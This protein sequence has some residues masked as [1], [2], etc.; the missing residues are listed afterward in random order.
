M[1][2]NAQNATQAR[3]KRLEKELN[4]VY[5]DAYKEV[6][7]QSASYFRNFSKRYWQEYEK[8]QNGEY[9]KAQFDAWYK[10]QV[11][12]GERWKKMQ[13]AIADRMTRT[14]QIAS[15]YI[16]D[17][18]AGIYSINANYTSY[19]ISQ[20]YGVPMAIYDEN[21]VRRL[22][23]QKNAVNFRTSSIN[24]KRDYLWN[25][26][27]VTR[28]LAS[29]I[30][31]GK[32]ID[33]MADA[34][35]DVMKRNR[36]AAIRNA[37]T[38]VTSAQNAGRQDSY[39]RA[40]EMGIELQKEWMCTHDDR[41]RDSHQDLDGERVGIHESFSNDLMFP[42][43]PSGSPSEV[44]NCR[45]TMV[46]VLPEVNNENRVTYDQWLSDQED[47]ESEKNIDIGA[48]IGNK[49]IAR[50]IKNNNL[51][52]VPYRNLLFKRTE[53][54]IIKS[55]SGFDLTEG[56]CVSAS[57]CYIGQKCGYNVLDFR[58]GKSRDW[59]ADLDN[60]K[61]LAKMDNIRSE[62]V[63]SKNSLQAGIEA[64][65]NI[66]NSEDMKE[67]IM[68]VG[69]HAAIVKNLGGGKLNYLELQSEY[70]NG[71]VDFSKERFILRDR[72]NCSNVNS[73]NDAYLFDVESFSGS[74]DFAEVIKYAN[75]K[76]SKQM[77]E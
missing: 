32:S 65:N 11:G 47:N 66:K 70:S 55:V 13:E 39:N 59:F 3:L 74:S 61:K 35:L 67:F 41:T 1:P 64:L 44:Y 62:V 73:Y 42:A 14:N 60:I 15:S 38:A 18:T 51:E 19:Q 53:E 27:Q 28:A 36:S 76:K 50:S 49:D 4:D 46:A 29:G 21:T 40:E 7:G 71:W 22:I 72:F 54:K 8:Y 63:K 34:F 69:E 6:R 77:K 68:V 48:G 58:G 24:K 75:T 20:S 2:Q 37:R 25:K 26:D 43:D 45:C 17:M 56:S 23:E 31:Q 5:S 16:N 10:S 12:R 52:K 30:I 9:T 33:Q 57:L